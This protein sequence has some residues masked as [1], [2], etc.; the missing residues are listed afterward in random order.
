MFRITCDEDGW[1][2]KVNDEKPYD[3]FFH[4]TRVSDI[5]QIR[6]TGQAIVS[7]V[8]I[9]KGTQHNITHL[10]PLTYHN[11]DLTPAPPVGFNL[12][13]Q[14]SEDEVFDHDWF[15]APFI[16]MTCQVRSVSPLSSLSSLNTSSYS[17]TEPSTSLTGLSI[18]V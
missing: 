18:S 14:C 5:R 17:L 8:G 3:V 10:K 2:L 13:F 11:L 15:A 6:F 12:T 4:V 7:Y 16:M 1:G 9:G